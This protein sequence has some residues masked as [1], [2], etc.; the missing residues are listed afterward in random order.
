MGTTN[1]GEESRTR[2]GANERDERR[3]LNPGPC[4]Q[5]TGG[6]P[7]DESRSAPLMR[8]PPSG[9]KEPC[10]NCHRAALTPGR[11]K[12]A[13]RDGVPK[14][15]SVCV[16]WQRERERRPARWS[17]ARLLPSNLG[18]AHWRD[19]VWL[20]PPGRLCFSLAAAVPLP[21]SACLPTC[22]C[23]CEAC[24]STYSSLLSPKLRSRSPSL[25]ALF[26]SLTQPIR[27]FS[28]SHIL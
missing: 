5:P 1:M 10:R 23:V 22:A 8:F 26:P 3:A 13:C 17:L 2:E 24:C 14:C 20:A 21:L 27:L 25:H 9:C 19:C 28:Y 18:R 12:V 7:G 11:P 15:A 6:E 4:T 16:R